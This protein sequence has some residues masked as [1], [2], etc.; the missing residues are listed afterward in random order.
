MRTPERANDDLVIVK[1]VIE[2]ARQFSD[3]DAPE[4]GNTGLGVEIA[5]SWQDSQYLH[6]SFKFC[7]EQFLVISVP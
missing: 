2:V 1:R 4:A 3:V 7:G 5:C 6:R